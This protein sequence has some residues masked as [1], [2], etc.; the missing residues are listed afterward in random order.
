MARTRQARVT[1]KVTAALAAVLKARTLGEG[2]RVTC[3]PS[4]DQVVESM[5]S[6]LGEAVKV[7][8]G[9][10]GSTS[11]CSEPSAPD[12]EYTSLSLSRLNEW[13][14][15][16]GPPSTPSTAEMVLGLRAAGCEAQ[17]DAAWASF[18]AQYPAE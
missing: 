4:G 9:S 10:G 3:L 13:A 17:A 5:F 11:W 14:K 7:V 6:P 16:G 18:C 2:V 1:D 12:V 15:N 8:I